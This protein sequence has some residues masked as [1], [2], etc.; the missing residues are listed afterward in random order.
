DYHLSGFAALGAGRHREARDLLIRAIELD[1]ANYWAHVALGTTYER[2][3]K[4]ADAV[5]CFSTA[6]ALSPEVSWGYYNR[7]VTHPQLRDYQKARQ[8]LTRAAELNPDHGETYLNRS[9]AA[10]GLKDY[11]GA[12]EDLDT[13]IVKSGPKIRAA[14]MKARIRDLAGD[15]EAAKRDL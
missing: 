3:Q 9:L 4:Y 1:P 11:A 14:L 15:K 13:A 2:I 6:I 5:A 7:G 12:L 10:Q 8:D